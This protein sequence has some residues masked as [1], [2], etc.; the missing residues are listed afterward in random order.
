MGEQLT[1]QRYKLRQGKL[2][3][4][5]AGE[6]V[7]WADVEAIVAKLP[8]TADGVPVVPGMTLWTRYFGVPIKTQPEAFIVTY[9]S[10]AGGEFVIGNETTISIPNCCYSTREAAE[11][12]EKRTLHAIATEHGIDMSKVKD[13]ESFDVITGKP[14]QE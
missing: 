11:A 3:K 9:I 4:N 10:P 7:R 8:K 2:R 12:K 13:Q 14:M 1:I 5:D 6:W